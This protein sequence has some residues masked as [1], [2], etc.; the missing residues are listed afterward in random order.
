MWDD[1]QGYEERMNAMADEQFYRQM[2]EATDLLG[3][4][5][6]KRAAALLERL[7][8]LFPN[9]IDVATNLSAAYIMNKQ[10]KKAVPILEAASRIA[11]DNPAIWSNLAAAYLG[12]LYTSTRERQDQ[13]INAYE[14]VLAINPAY[15]NTYYNLGLI[16]EDRKEWEMARQMFENALKID[17][18]DRDARN[19]MTRMQ[20]MIDDNPPK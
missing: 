9:D 16:Y 6:S 3:K 8:D 17:P 13:A 14:H 11:A 7:Y 18:N 15:P 12:A 2:R 4:N 5:E 19:L 10:Y 20:R 1:E